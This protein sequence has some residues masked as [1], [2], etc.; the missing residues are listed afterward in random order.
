MCVCAYLVPFFFR[1]EFLL[2]SVLLLSS[3][4]VNPPLSRVTDSSTVDRCL[5]GGQS[6]YSL[7]FAELL[8]PV[9]LYVIRNRVTQQGGSDREAT[10]DVSQCWGGDSSLRLCTQETAILLSV[11]CPSQKDHRVVVWLDA[12]QQCDVFRCFMSTVL[13]LTEVFCQLPSCF[14]H[15]FVTHVLFPQS[16]FLSLSHC[17][18]LSPSLFFSPPMLCLIVFF[19]PRSWVKVSVA[20]EIKNAVQV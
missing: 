16:L 8:G 3:R 2:F 1:K 4:A 11:K 10:A 9:S 7:R 15:N 17:Q 14:F 19:F 12:P 18:S 6:T 5:P 13:N 20:T